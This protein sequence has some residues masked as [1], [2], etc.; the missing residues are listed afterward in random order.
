MSVEELL[1]SELTLVETNLSQLESTLLFRNGISDYSSIIPTI[2][3]E[4]SDSVTDSVILKFVRVYQRFLSIFRII[5][6]SKK[7]SPEK[8]S[9]ESDIQIILNFISTYE[10]KPE[11]NGWL[12]IRELRNNLVHRFDPKLKGQSETEINISKIR[13]YSIIFKGTIILLRENK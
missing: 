9:L 4:L 12:Q 10:L 6:P 8:K 11:M 1:L 2:Y 3:L 5:C 7:K 13:E